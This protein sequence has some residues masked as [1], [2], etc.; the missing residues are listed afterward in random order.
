MA[1]FGRPDVPLV[2]LYVA[3]VVSGFW[4]LTQSLSPW[5]SKDVQLRIPGPEV[6][7]PVS[8][9]YIRSADMPVW[10]PAARLF[11]SMAGSTMRRLGFVRSK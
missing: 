11:S 3:T 5:L 10:V 6:S 2:E 9:T 8:N 4:T 7:S 1:A